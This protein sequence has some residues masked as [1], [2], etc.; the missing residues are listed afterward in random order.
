MASL[1]L[2]FSQLVRPQ[3]TNL[4]F[5]S[6]L[7]SSSFTTSCVAAMSSSTSQKPLPK[8]SNKYDSGV[9]DQVQEPRML[10]L[11]TQVQYDREFVTQ[12]LNFERGGRGEV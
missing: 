10:G 9:E 1:V 11:E 7:A 4:A 2:L 6:T 5:V 12:F 8:D 3:N